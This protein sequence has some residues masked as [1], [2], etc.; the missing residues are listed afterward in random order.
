MPNGEYLLMF[1]T[2]QTSLFDTPKYIR[3]PYGRVS[4]NKPTTA[5]TTTLHD[6]KYESKITPPAS[7]NVSNTTENN[8]VICNDK[9]DA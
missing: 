6:S 2:N 8:Y 7:R 3:K 1:E 5:T 4:F 9:Y